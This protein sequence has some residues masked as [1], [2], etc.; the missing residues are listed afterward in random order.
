MAAAP[1][2]MAMSSDRPPV[3]ALPTAPDSET[4]P[5]EI[6]SLSF[7][8]TW[9]L[10]PVAL[11][12]SDVPLNFVLSTMLLISEPIWPISDSIAD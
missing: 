8:P 1:S 4:A 11:L 9:N 12:S 2:L 6:V 3:P 7:A 5:V 10:K